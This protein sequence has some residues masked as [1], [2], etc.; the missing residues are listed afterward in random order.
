MT[1]NGIKIKTTAV[2]PPIPYPIA[3]I[4]VRHYRVEF[5]RDKLPYN[6]A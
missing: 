4:M 3:W 6:R 1:Y 5:S 2:F